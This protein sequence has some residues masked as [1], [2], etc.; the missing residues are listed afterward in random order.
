M[1]STIRSSGGGLTAP[2]PPIPGVRRSGRRPA[3]SGRPAP[4]RAA[5]GIAGRRP[6]AARSD[7]NADSRALASTRTSRSRRPVSSWASSC[8]RLSSRPRNARTAPVPRRCQLS[9]RCPM[10]TTGASTAATAP[11]RG[12]HSEPGPVRGRSQ[13]RPEQ[14][15]P[16][17]RGCPAAGARLRSARSARRRRETQA[18]PGIRRGLARYRRRSAGPRSFC[19]SASRAAMSSWMAVRLGLDLCRAR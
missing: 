5:R 17:A 14:Q 9:S 11:I 18:S 13:D 10:A 8:C 6:G 16:W 12:P 3:W 2:L 1:Y 15:N 19:A 7:R 4:G